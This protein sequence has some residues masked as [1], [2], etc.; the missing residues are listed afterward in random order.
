M[1]NLYAATKDL[2][3]ACEEHSLGQRMVHA[4]V[5]AQEWADWL[6]AFRWMHFHADQ[7]VPFTME[8]DWLFDA[9]L[10]E[11]GRRYGVVGRQSKA[12]ARWLFGVEW[13]DKEAA[14]YV[15]HG[16]HKR[17]GRLLAP[18]LAACKLPSA[19]TYY[20]LPREA[21][22]VVRGFRERDD[23]IEPARQVFATL[24]EV[25]DEITSRGERE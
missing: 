20:P 17:G 9:D 16:A 14:A 4:A 25:M 12:V 3:H 19:H 23:L 5:T 24:L 11:L 8:R 10:R 7:A 15:L 1:T 13:R 18:I 2:H 22:E 21:E 6:Q